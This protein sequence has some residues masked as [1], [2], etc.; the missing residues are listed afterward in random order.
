MNQVGQGT[1]E[2]VHRQVLHFFEK[3]GLLLFWVAQGDSKSNAFAGETT[4][5]IFL[6]YITFSVFAETTD[7]NLEFCYRCENLTDIRRASVMHE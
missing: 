5:I 1:F 2:K 7:T 4:I 6:F 3:E